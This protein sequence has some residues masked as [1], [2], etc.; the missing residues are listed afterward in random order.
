MTVEPTTGR[1]SRWLLVLGA[2]AGVIVVLAGV[3]AIVAFTWLDVSLNDGVGDRSYTP[4]SAGGVQREYKL[5]VG[6]L[7]LDLSRVPTGQKVD[8]EAHVG[9][10][11]L[12]VIV[13]AAAS[14]GVDARVKAGSVDALGRNDDGRNARVRFSGTNLRLKARVGAGRI[15]VV[16][17]R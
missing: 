10:G 6:N 15:E 3:A 12:R 17:A 1:R 14:V 16:S 4:S 8:V 7:T 13:P 2:I 9:L 11:K 5:G